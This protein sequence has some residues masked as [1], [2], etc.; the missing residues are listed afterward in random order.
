M[1]AACVRHVAG[2]GVLE[3]LTLEWSL[4]IQKSSHLFSVNSFTS[5]VW[6]ETASTDMERWILAASRHFVTYSMRDPYFDKIRALLLL[7]TTS[8]ATRVVISRHRVH[9]V[10]K[11][12]QPATNRQKH[13]VIKKENGKRER[14]IKFQDGNTRTNMLIWFRVCALFKHG[15]S[16]RE[17]VG[18]S[19]PNPVDVLRKDS[20]NNRYYKWSVESGRVC[21][22]HL[23]SCPQHRLLGQSTLCSWPSS[24]AA[25][26]LGTHQKICHV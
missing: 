2:S 21:G 1:R 18:E 25:L 8:D 9:R 5:E 4:V 23:V 24:R 10:Q 12:R 7:A 14:K 3:H 15:S 22:R 11:S 13:S 17:C 19:V 20:A 6:Y 26:S 16:Q